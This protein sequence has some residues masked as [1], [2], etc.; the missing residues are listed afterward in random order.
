MLSGHPA[1]EPYQRWRPEPAFATIVALGEGPRWAVTVGGAGATGGEGVD[2]NLGDCRRLPVAGGPRAPD[3]SGH[4]APR[5]APVRTG[6][7]VLGD[8]SVSHRLRAIRRCS[9]ARPTW[10]ASASTIGRRQASACW[11][12]W[13]GRRG[14]A[15]PPVAGSGPP[16]RGA[17]ARFMS[18]RYDLVWIFGARPWVL[19]G[20]QAF[21]PT[22]VDLDD[23]ED[24]KILARLSVPRPPARSWSGWQLR[25]TGSRVIA[26]EEIRRWR[27]LHRRA[28][29]R[30]SAIVVCSSLDAGRVDLGRSG[31]GGSRPQRLPVRRAA[32][33]GAPASEHHPP[34]SSRDC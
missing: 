7:A 4:G 34:C 30:A 13:P 32:R 16:C 14:A 18:G 10:P 17:L 9:G 8:L 22:I 21:A 29:K 28:A 12:R 6:R 5:P 15:G 11:P 25:K 33:R 24:Q 31:P 19:S 1:R 23:L 20:E 27:R 2:A 26:D 3:A